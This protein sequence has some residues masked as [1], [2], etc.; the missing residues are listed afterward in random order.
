MLPPGRFRLATSPAAT[1]SNPTW[2]TIGIIAVAALDACAAAP[3][4]N[5]DQR[6]DA[7]P[8]DG[9]GD[10]TAICDVGSF[11]AADAGRIFADGFDL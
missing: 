10:G 4:S 3:V 5:L 9:N 7:R 6:G 2:K 11:E 8:V 1:G